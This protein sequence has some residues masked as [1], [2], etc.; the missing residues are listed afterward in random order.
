MKKKRYRRKIIFEKKTSGLRVRPGYK[1]THQVDRVLSGCYTGQSFNKSGPIQPP[2][3][4]GFNNF[5][6]EH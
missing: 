4:P 6:L 1:S 2:D 5:S 3:W